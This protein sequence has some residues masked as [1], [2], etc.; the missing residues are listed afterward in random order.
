MVSESISL[1]KKM[2]EKMKTGDMRVATALSIIAQHF[3]II[4]NEKAY[5][6]IR[7]NEFK[8]SKEETVE[9][10][11]YMPNLTIEIFVSQK[12]NEPEDVKIYIT[13]DAI[14]CYAR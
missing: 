13:R 12:E 8:L 10:F 1:L 11:I 2:C 4:I 6:A 5:L 14:E 3:N 9:M 7:C